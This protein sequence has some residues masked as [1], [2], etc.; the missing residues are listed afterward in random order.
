MRCGKVDRQGGN[1]RDAVNLPFCFVE[2]ALR[3]NVRSRVHHF[4]HL[5]ISTQLA[6]PPG[7]QCGQ[8]AQSSRL[9]LVCCRSAEHVSVA[10]PYPERAGGADPGGGGSHPGHRA[11]RRQVSQGRKRE[12]LTAL[13]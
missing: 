9:A 8:D 13:S 5:C 12:S 7:T 4:H 1:K 2:F 11:L 6:V 10:V 3:G